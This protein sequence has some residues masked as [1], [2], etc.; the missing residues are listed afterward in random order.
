[1]H[2]VQ[3][4]PKPVIWIGDSRRELKSFPD[5]V[6]LDI[7]AA[8]FEAQ[9]GSKSVKAKPLSGIGSGILEVVADHRGDTFRAVYTLKIRGFVIVLHVFQKKSNKG[10]ATP[11][12][13]MEL[14]EQRMKKAL[15]DYGE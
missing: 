9:T 7:G 6:R 8:L 15:E 2:I 1:M 11:K 12:R 14:V 13:E 5:Q 3:P 10:I 4:I